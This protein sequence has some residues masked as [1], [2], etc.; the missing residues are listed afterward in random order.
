MNLRLKYVQSDVIYVSFWNNAPLPR[1]LS[2]YQLTKH[3]LL[4]FKMARGGGEQ[5]EQR[6]QQCKKNHCNYRDTLALLTLVR[7]LQNL[8][9]FNHIYPIK[10]RLCRTKDGASKP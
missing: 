7:S 2:L 1:L 6:A 10:T 8:L 5:P 9:C 3:G 4:S